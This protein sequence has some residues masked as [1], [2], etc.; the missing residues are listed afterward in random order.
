MTPLMLAPDQYQSIY[1]PKLR[2]LQVMP[3]SELLPTIYSRQDAHIQVVRCLFWALRLLFRFAFLVASL[4]VKIYV[5]VDVFV[6]LIKLNR[7][8]CILNF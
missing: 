2:A 3:T 8:T 1:K 6:Y 4:F 5:A 7:I